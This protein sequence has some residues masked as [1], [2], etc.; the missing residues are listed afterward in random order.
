MTPNGLACQD[1]WESSQVLAYVEGEMPEPE[2]RNFVQHLRNCAACSAEVESFRELSRLL[3]SHPESFHPAAAKL[4]E[5]IST[6]SDPDGWI[7]D[8]VASCSE[9]RADVELVRHIGEVEFETP[10]MSRA[11][12]TSLV[13]KMQALYR[14]PTH[15]VQTKTLMSRLAEKFG[16][17][18][19]RLPVLALGTAAAAL[20]VAVLVTPLFTTFRSISQE[21]TPP[22]EK[23]VPPAGSPMPLTKEHPAGLGASRKREMHENQPA[24]EV[25]MPKKRTA[26]VPE[27]REQAAQSKPASKGITR[28]AEQFRS[29][30]RRPD[31]ST[32]PEKP[33]QEAPAATP[34]K[35]LSRSG[36]SDA[37]LPASPR[38]FSPKRIPVAVEILDSRDAAVPRMKFIVPKGL[39]ETYEFSHV[40]DRAQ[41]EMMGPVN[42]EKTP[43]KTTTKG[44][45]IRFQLTVSGEFFDVR[46]ELFERGATHPTKSLTV[47]KVG[48]EELSNQISS[49]AAN[50]LLDG[51]PDEEFSK[52][53]E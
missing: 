4:Y 20:L 34:L 3:K 49:I 41:D 50:L 23:V 33:S 44:L 10:G 22:E 2:S 5:F 1:G 31:S 38:V 46:G 18:P 27:E 6:G 39:S 45:L 9:C 24:A 40:R 30:V 17:Y 36:Q 13:E 26:P 11:M 29:N 52:R 8:H 37:P 21:S 53:K 14:L 47:T 32:S 42:P 7:S 12:P 25:S 15:S 19:M 35:D 28:R 48:K 51:L 16:I 43:G